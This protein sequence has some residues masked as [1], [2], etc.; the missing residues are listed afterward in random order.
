LTPDISS[1]D[2]GQSWELVASLEQERD[3]TSLTKIEQSNSG[4]FWVVGGAY[5]IE[6]IYGLLA[7]LNG[8]GGGQK[9]RTS[10]VFFKDAVFLSEHDVIASGSVI[11]VG[12]EFPTR[13][14][15]D[16]AIF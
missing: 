10:G 3:Q 1:S 13:G 2:A 12:I 6:G 15:R 4:Q 16:G 9:Y 8:D 14:E 7:R 5:S 11:P